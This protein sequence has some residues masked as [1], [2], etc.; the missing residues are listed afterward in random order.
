MDTTSGAYAHYDMK[1]RHSTFIIFVVGVV[2]IGAMKNNFNGFADIIDVRIEINACE[3]KFHERKLMVESTAHRQD[4]YILSNAAVLRVPRHATPLEETFRIRLGVV[5][6]LIINPLHPL[7]ST[8]TIETVNVST[9]KRV[10]NKVIGNPSAKL[11]LAQDELFVATS[12]TALSSLS[13]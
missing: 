8:M 7:R 4:L 6:S 1:I 5:V 3:L 13:L 12:V 10:K 11:M 2:E 9:L